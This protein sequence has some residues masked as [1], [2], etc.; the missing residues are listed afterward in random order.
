MAMMAKM[1]NLA[2]AFI[3]AVGGIFV[4]FMVISDSRVLQIFGQRSNDVGSVNGNPISYKQFSTLVEQ[5]RQRQK[6]QTGKDIEEENTDAFNDQ[7]WDALV[8]QELIKEQIEKFGITVTGEEINDIIFGANPPD[9]LKRQFIDSLGRF[10]K[11]LYETT[12]QR[13]KKEVLLAIEEQVRQ[14]RLQEKL[15]NY[16]FGSITVS[17]GEVKRKFIDMNTK[18]DAN[19]I[20]VDAT[21]IPD[22]DVKVDDSDIKKY[23]DAHLEDFK[24][25]AQRKL[26][27]VLFSKAANKED[28]STIKNN[29]VAVMNKAKGDTASFKTYIDIYSEQPYK[30]DTIKQ[31]AIPQ[32]ATSAFANAAPGTILGPYATPEGYIVYKVL[33]KVPSKESVV[34]ASHILIQMNGDEAKAL[35]EANSIY[36]QLTSGAD[37]AK[38]AME[39][40]ADP[41]SARKGGDLGWFGKGQ[42]VKEFEDACFNGPIGVVQKP[43]KSSFGYHIIKVTGKSNSDYVVEKLVNRIKASGTTVEN[44]YASAG[45]F[46][47]LADKGDF[48]NEAKIEKLK[49]LETPDFVKDATYIPGV[50]SNKNLVDWAFDSDLNDLSDIF[51]VPSG[52]IVA[53]VSE[54]V[55]EGV[56]KFEDVQKTIKPLVLKEKKFEK[57]K[58]I[59]DK[60]YSQLKSGSLQMENASSVNP[61]IRFDTTGTI[62]PVQAV[63]KVG[64]DYVF[65]DELMKQPLNKIS[66]PFKGQRGY[67]IV[68]VLKRNDFD[69]S[70][71]SIQKNSLRSSILQEKKSYF[72]NQWLTQIKKSADI[73]DNRRLFYR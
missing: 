72:F 70:A 41:G 46:K 73:V 10:N 15:Q 40:S 63:P 33:G 59:A 19:Y 4:L 38:L 8:T 58:G 36:S 61:I 69:K 71:F 24:V 37:F 18:M 17:D 32:E 14:T 2:P 43:V 64:R 53:Y 67:F 1:R 48:E 66:E 28:S 62:T 22:K 27:Y 34:K 7:I 49:V 5:A 3:I 57:A 42:M 16:L 60:V 54:V 56:K 65:N 26:K 35:A 21:A 11:Q 31:T 13:Q 9:F 55:K 20:L 39:K 44:A 45:D 23:Y 6:E 25:E 51:K 29:L 68:K 47:Y 12:I 52:Y 30:K 50:G